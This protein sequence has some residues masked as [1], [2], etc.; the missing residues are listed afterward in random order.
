M[1]AP[2]GR[3]PGRPVVLTEAVGEWME[4][5]VRTQYL[6]RDPITSAELLDGI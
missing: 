2:E 5:T 6:Q 1:A 3:R 4:N